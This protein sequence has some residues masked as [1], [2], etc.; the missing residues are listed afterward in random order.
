MFWTRSAANRVT[1]ARIARLEGFEGKVPTILQREFMPSR[2]TQEE[3]LE[4]LELLHLDL[5]A[6]FERNWIRQELPGGVP[7]QVQLL[8][9]DETRGQL[10]VRH[11]DGGLELLPKA[12]K[13]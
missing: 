9:V 13:A 11:K 8:A 6:Q 3:R 4:R 5:I 1:E 2:M 7:R 10:L 12:P